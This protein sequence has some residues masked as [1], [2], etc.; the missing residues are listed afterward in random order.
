[1]I[2]SKLSMSTAIFNMGRVLL[3]CIMNRRKALACAATGIV[4]LSGCAL[5]QS[6]EATI[7]FENRF[8]EGDDYQFVYYLERDG[9]TTEPA[10]VTV[11]PGDSKK[12][13]EPMSLG[14]AVIGEY[15]HLTYRREIQDVICY[16]P[17][18]IFAVQNTG[19]VAA[20]GC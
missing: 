13:T 10:T 1:M 18:I 16:N 15:E 19:F 7:I 20:G 6:V 12:I 14:D 11:G 5:V 9:V 3:Q 2:A 17:K 4:G 8:E